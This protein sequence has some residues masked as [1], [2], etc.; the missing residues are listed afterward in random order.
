MNTRDALAVG[1][2]IGAFVLTMASGFGTL[3][4]VDDADASG[5]AMILFLLR[6]SVEGM[7]FCAIVSTVT[8]QTSSLS[9]AK[10]RF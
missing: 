7:Q 4:L 5:G 2:W 1:V 9:F 10:A 3:L 6:L 8:Y